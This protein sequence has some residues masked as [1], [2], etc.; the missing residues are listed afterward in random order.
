MYFEQKIELNCTI[1]TLIT[2][3]CYINK[4]KK[5]EGIVVQFGLD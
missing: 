1:N 2:Y 5:I 3:H 4:I